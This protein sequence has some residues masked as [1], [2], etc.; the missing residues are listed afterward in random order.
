MPQYGRMLGPRAKTKAKAGE[1][2]RERESKR[3]PATS[4]PKGWET[5]DLEERMS[6]D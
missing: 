5:K 6:S 4:A 2:E 3:T 1:R